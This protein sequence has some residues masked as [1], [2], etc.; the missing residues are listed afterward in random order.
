MR[1]IAVANQKGGVGKSTTAA[2]M[3]TE[4]ALRGYETLL[5]DGDPQANVTSH[6]LAADQV[7]LSIADVL[8]ESDQKEKLPLEAAIVTT[9]LEHLDLVPAKLRFARFEKEPAIAINRLRSKLAS[10][11]DA[12]DFV[13]IDTPPTLGQILTTPLL[14]SQY[15]LVPVAAS[16]LAQDGLEDLMSTFEEVQSANPD[17]KLLGILCTLFDSRTSVSAESY[18]ALKQR[19]PAQIFETIIHRNVK[20]EEAP[21]FNQ[22]VQLYAPNSRG[23]LLYAELTD[24]TLARMGERKTKSSLKLAKAAGDEPGTD[25]GKVT[26]FM[27]K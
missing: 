17:L 11:A 16:P 19:Y 3:A 7:G 23:A 25:K 14:A 21:A 22:P 12:Y 9:E 26:S 13:V 5:I 27:P 6:F 2:S 8:I 15:M 4:F 18:R 24:E 20:L 10:L 1:T